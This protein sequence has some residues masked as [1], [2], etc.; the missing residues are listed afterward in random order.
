MSWRRPEESQGRRLQQFW[1]SNLSFYFPQ[2]PL[3]RA[4]DIG[5]YIQ[6]WMNNIN[7]VDFNSNKYFAFPQKVIPIYF[8]VT[9]LQTSAYIGGLLL[10]GL[11]KSVSQSVPIKTQTNKAVSL[12]SPHLPHLTTLSSS[13]FLSALTALSPVVQSTSPSPLA[14]S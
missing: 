14:Q 1:T 10:A 7:W 13:C 2:S 9:E 12:T 4:V 8:N 5:T 6:S 3:D 11:G